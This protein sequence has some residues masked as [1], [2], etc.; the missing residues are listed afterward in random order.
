ML[1]GFFKKK[2]KNDFQKD[3][4]VKILKWGKKFAD[5]EL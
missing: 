3:I 4:G 1:I 2:A 5:G